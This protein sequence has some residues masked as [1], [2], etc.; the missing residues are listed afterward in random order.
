M[1]VKKWLGALG[2]VVA[3]GLLS[4]VFFQTGISGQA[5]GEKAPPVFV[6]EG[7]AP[8]SV[9]KLLKVSQA[10]KKG[11]TFF[12]NGEAIPGIV[13]Q[14]SGDGTVEVRNQEFGK[15]LIRLDRVDAVAMN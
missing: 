12:V 10:E 15:I 4:V 8:A 14:A 7:A 3:V 2:V 13:T 11:L 5:A 1:R 9:A 6:P